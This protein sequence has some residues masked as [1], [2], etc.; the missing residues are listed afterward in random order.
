ML[1]L[2]LVARCATA[3]PMEKKD[4]L[5]VHAA[6]G[7]GAGIITNGSVL[8]TG[9]GGGV[10]EIG[11]CAPIAPEDS[12]HKHKLIKLD[13]EADA[14][15]CGCGQRGHLEGMAGGEA[16]VRRL[17]SSLDHPKVQ[18]PDQL[19]EQ[20]T[21]PIVSYS[22]ALD[23]IL[24]ELDKPTPWAPAVAALRDAGYMVGGAV[25]TL[26]HLF[27][28]EAVYLTG[29]LS[30]AG[31]PYLK[32]VRDGFKRTGR[33]QNYEPMIELGETLDGTDGFGRRLLMV[34]GAAMTAVRATRSL[35]WE[36]ELK[37]MGL[38]KS[39]PKKQARRKKK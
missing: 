3:R 25:H 16:I 34:R 32:A 30:D 31:E 38:G 11:H 19:A 2:P 27:R 29:R 4:V 12:G 1:T 9:S 6:Y 35:I 36:D 7:L 33:L 24:D 37:A 18:P 13:P 23:A 15:V 8:K 26:V 21:T 17:A 39:L 5:V 20:L 10:G 22:S 14:F 28:P